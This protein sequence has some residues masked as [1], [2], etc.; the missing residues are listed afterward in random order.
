MAN[1]LEISVEEMSKY[2]DDPVGLN[3]TCAVFSESELIGKIA[4]GVPLE[5]LY[6]G[7]NYSLYNRLK[8]LLTKFRG[9]SLIV[10]GGVANNQSI[11]EYL[12][13]DYDEIIAVEDPQFN[14]AIGC[15]YYGSL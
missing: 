4:E 10:T 15:C 11:V 7:V 8:P 12:S 1:V 6:A 5:R 13:A 14:G 2:H 9:K 3:S